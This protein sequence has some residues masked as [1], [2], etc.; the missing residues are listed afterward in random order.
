MKIAALRGKVLLAGAVVAVAPLIMVAPANADATD[1][2]FISSLDSS[3]LDYDSAAEAIRMAK[4]VCTLLGRSPGEDR[5]RSA[6]TYLQKNTDYA[7]SKIQEFG[8]AAVKAYCPEN[9]P[10]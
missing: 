7:Q 1:D 10:S 4:K 2:T 5:I 3:G 6:V 8:I 9:A